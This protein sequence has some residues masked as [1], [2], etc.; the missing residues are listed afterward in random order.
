VPDIDRQGET[1]APDALSACHRVVFATG[2]ERHHTP[3]RDRDGAHRE[4]PVDPRRIARALVQ[5]KQR[6]LVRHSLSTR[7]FDFGVRQGTVLAPGRNLTCRRVLDPTTDDTRSFEMKT[8]MYAAAIACTVAVAGPAAAQGIIGGA[9]EGAAVG[10]NAAGPIGGIVGGAVGAGVGGATGAVNGV[11][12]VP[13]ER[14]VR[15]TERRRT[16][17]TTTRQAPPAAGTLSDEDDDE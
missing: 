8:F 12:G 3:K 15:R 10:S 17:T 13:Q 11:L 1:V 2:Y 7:C 5:Q 6:R 9:E 4:K 16:T 14:A